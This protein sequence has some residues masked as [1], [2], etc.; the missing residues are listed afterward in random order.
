MT[1]QAESAACHGFGRAMVAGAGVVEGRGKAKLVAVGLRVWLGCRDAA[2]ASPDESTR[3]V[4]RA[5]HDEAG[6]A[7]VV[8]ILQ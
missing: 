1:A 3:L 6:A 7:P 2:K 4:P 8:S 5:K